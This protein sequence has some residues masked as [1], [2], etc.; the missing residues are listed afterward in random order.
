MHHHSFKRDFFFWW[1]HDEF[2][3]GR[4]KLFRYAIFIKLLPVTTSY[5]PQ[6]GINEGFKIFTIPLRPL[7]DICDYVINTRLLRWRV[8]EFQFIFQ[9]LVKRSASTNLTW[10]N[11]WPPCAGHRSRP[12]LFWTDCADRSQ[13]SAW[14]DTGVHF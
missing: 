12:G 9:L 8:Q 6:P 7:K 3:S 2:Q 1:F 13:S 11:F 10:L 4:R 5:Q 14:C